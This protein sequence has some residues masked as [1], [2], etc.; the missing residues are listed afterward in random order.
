L[1]TGRSGS[2]TFFPIYAT[3]I[4][5]FKAKLIPCDFQTRGRPKKSKFISSLDTVISILNGDTILYMPDAENLLFVLYVVD[6]LI[7]IGTWPVAAE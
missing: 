2:P 7:D 5:F 3:V 1:L 4:V 6:F